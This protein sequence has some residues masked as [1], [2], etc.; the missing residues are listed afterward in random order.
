MADTNKRYFD[1]VKVLFCVNQK[2]MSD[3]DPIRIST[4]KVCI[5]CQG[6]LSFPMYSD[7]EFNFPKTIKEA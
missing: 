1:N 7:P 3:H 5:P 6:E 2:F 4:C